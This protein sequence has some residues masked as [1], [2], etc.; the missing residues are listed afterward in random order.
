MRFVE[1]LIEG[2]AGKQ[3]R[4]DRG[5]ALNELKRVDTDVGWSWLVSSRTNLSDQLT[6]KEVTALINAAEAG[7]YEW[8]FDEGDDGSNWPVGLLVIHPREHF[9]KKTYGKDLELASDP[10]Q[11]KV[12]ELTRQLNSV[13]DKFNEEPGHSPKGQKEIDRINTEIERIYDEMDKRAEELD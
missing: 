4:S 13:Y 2:L 12:Q 1:F 5:W 9:T 8:Y 7:G 10:L 11:R 6:E 3:V